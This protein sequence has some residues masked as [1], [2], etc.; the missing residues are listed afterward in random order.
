MRNR[1][2]RLAIG[3]F[4]YERLIMQFQCRIR[5]PH[6]LRRIPTS[7]LKRMRRPLHRELAR[8]GKGNIAALQSNGRLPSLYHDFLIGFDDNIAVGTGD[9][10]TC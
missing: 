2:Q 8:T 4:D 1:R 3:V 10:L 6:N 9:G 5:Q 7:Q